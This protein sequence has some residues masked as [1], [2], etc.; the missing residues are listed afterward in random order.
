M[1]LGLIRWVQGLAGPGYLC[2]DDVVVEKP[3][4]KVL[5]WAGWTYSH[6]QKRP[7]FGFHIVLLFW[8]HKTLRIPV[9]FR[10]WRPKREGLPAYRTKLELA[11]TLITMVLRAGLSFE[12]LTFDSW[13]NARWFT[14]WLNA[15]QLIWVST[16]KANARVTY[17]GRTQAVAELA[18]QLPRHRIAGNTRA[19]TGS[20]YLPE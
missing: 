16:L 7:V 13:Y 9:G 10:L 14:K 19:W 15:Q 2:L 1:L 4:A 3:F 8:C 6:S 11:Q 12:Y 17:R 5:A 20:V 18:S